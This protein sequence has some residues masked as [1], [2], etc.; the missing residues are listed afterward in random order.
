MK[1]RFKELFEEVLN[2]LELSFPNQEELDSKIQSYK[3]RLDVLMEDKFICI[4][5]CPELDSDKSRHC[6]FMKS[7]IDDYNHNNKDLCPCGNGE[8]LQLIS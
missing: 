4:S 8:V 2:E 6:T 7:T 5:P 1:E 3:D